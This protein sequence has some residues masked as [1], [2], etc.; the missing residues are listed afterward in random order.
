MS[1]H[2]KNT[3]SLSD[4]IPDLLEEKYVNFIDNAENRGH[5]RRSEE[6]PAIDE[7]LQSGGAATDMTASR[8]R[9]DILPL[10]PQ[11]ILEIGC[12]AGL[13]CFALQRTYP[14]AD[15]LGI[16][17]E[18]K[19]I[20]L[21][22]EFSTYLSFEYRN[23][24]FICGVGEHIPLVS[25]SVDLVVCHT[26]IEHVSDVGA[27]ITEIARVLRPGG[28]LHLEAPNYVWPYEPHLNVWCVPMF[29]KKFVW[30]CGLL[31]GAKNRLEFL[32]HLK[33]VTPFNLEREFERASLSWSN[34]VRKKM[35]DVLNGDVRQICHYRMLAQLLHYTSRLHISRW[36]INALIL[37]GI[38][39]SV[40]YTVTKNDD[41]T[42]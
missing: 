4:Q 24:T 42:R 28:K 34:R 16:D 41:D 21:A 11:V 19:A 32:N 2:P 31:Q 29:G 13:N 40:M 6:F 39:P 35:L 3:T 27:V 37:L 26:V 25:N 1:S 38:Y 15:V 8:I 10:I 17:P 30:L 5:A 33:F 12:S 9:Q 20:A 23:P 36:L 14:F 18:E 7:Y 22:N